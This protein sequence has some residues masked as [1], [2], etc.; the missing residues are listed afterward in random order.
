MR[1]FPSLRSASGGGKC[2]R[3]TH[4][5][6]LPDPRN[7]YLSLC[8][9]LRCVAI[10]RILHLLSPS[11]VPEETFRLLN[12]LPGGQYRIL[13]M[14]PMCRVKQNEVREYASGSWLLVKL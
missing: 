8:R 7:A 14:I 12:L 11:F 5:S 13:Q 2:S 6:F 1:L 10:R 3:K 9:R 4:R